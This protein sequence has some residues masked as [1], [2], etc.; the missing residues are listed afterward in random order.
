M[1]VSLWTCFPSSDSLMIHHLNFT[2]SYLIV[3]S[4]FRKLIDLIG[5]WV[6]RLKPTDFKHNLASS[7]PVQNKKCVVFFFGVEIFLAIHFYLS[8]QKSKNPLKKFSN[9]IITWLSH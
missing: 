5:Q 9:L 1:F 3:M 4:F 8:S 7:K 6:V 2:S